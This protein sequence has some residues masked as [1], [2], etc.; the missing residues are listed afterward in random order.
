[1]N[2]VLTLASCPGDEV[3]IRGP[4]FGIVNM[5]TVA[6]GCVWD[7]YLSSLLLLLELL[8]SVG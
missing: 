7:P 4:I 6:L 1:M 3:E 8:V 2:L 5:T